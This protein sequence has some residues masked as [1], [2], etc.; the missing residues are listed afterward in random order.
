MRTFTQISALR[1]YLRGIRLEGKQIGFVPTM[2]ALH[3]GHLSLV[4]RAARDCD[5]VVLSIYV[6]PR[7]FGPNEDFDAY[8]RD[9]QRDLQMASSAGVDAVLIPANE[10]MYPGG[11]Q[12][13]V[14]LPDLGGLLDGA[15]RPG[16]F[17]G[18]A[19]VVCKLLNI[20]QP[21]RAFFG[22]KDYQQIRVIE[23]MLLDL[24]I[25]CK[26]VMTP[27]LR[28]A[29]GLALSSRNS[30]L[31]AKERK[32]ATVIHRA[33][34]AVIDLTERGERRPKVLEEQMLE[35]LGTE[36]LIKVQYAS[37]V[38][39]ETLQPAPEDGLDRMVALIAAH[40]GRTRL[41]DNEVLIVEARFKDLS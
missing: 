7:Q 19:T 25:P 4:Q 1:T 8:P 29:D 36:P 39:S 3:E 11:Y 35:V 26:I 27:T 24:N 23:Q 5:L 21:D 20:V 40:V 30:Y 38:S 14:Q 28:A 18:V 13:V 37:V 34:C 31:N 9:L 32:A 16:H 15:H 12:T 2:G 6:N 33:L 10:E 41:I 17:D 22:Q